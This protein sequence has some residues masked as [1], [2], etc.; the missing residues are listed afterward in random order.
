MS[1]PADLVYDIAFIGSG[2]ACT[3]TL[4]AIIEQLEKAEK[5]TAPLK[6][7]VIEKYPEWWKGI[8]Y[9]NRSSVNAL[10]ITTLHDFFTDIT[11]R[12]KFLNR[13]IPQKDKLIASYLKTGGTIAGTWLKSNKN[14][15]E[16]GDWNNV[17][18]PRS[19]I[20]QY[21]AKTFKAL[22]EQARSKN[23]IKIDTLTGEAVAVDS[24]ENYK[25]VIIAIEAHVAQIRARKIVLAI[26][27]APQRTLTT[28]F[29][30]QDEALY[31]NNIHGQDLEMTCEAIKKA[32]KKNLTAQRNIFIAGANASA[33][34]LL[35]L[36]ND[37]KEL[38]DLVNNIT[39][40]SYG[41]S[42]PKGITYT[43][44]A[45]RLTENLEK[46]GLKKTY[47][48]AELVE[49]AKKD[50]LKVIDGDVS[51]PDVD[52]IM[53]KTIALLTPLDI[54]S[55]KL[56]YAVH[57][58]QLARIFRRSGTDYKNAANNLVTKNKLT[59]LK[60][61][62][63]NIS[64]NSDGSTSIFYEVEDGVQCLT[65]HFAVVV[66]CTGADDLEKTTSKLIQN[67]INKNG[68]KI[69]QSRKAFEVDS[70][71]QAAEGIYVIGPLAGGNYNELLYFWHLE[72]AS[73]IIYLSKHLAKELVN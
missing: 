37:D 68:L 48:L 11:E 27:S 16:Q 46:L 39:M 28:A 47:S 67:L 14:A 41:G 33:I 59:V 45:H 35:Y 54:Q 3:A 5:K 51:V 22:K 71:L 12:D 40:L 23:L 38:S 43:T 58:V 52:Q 49:A 62:L 63:Q 10:T 26:G 19:I 42:L 70:H 21:L 4:T 55:K 32:L 69:N 65:D 64:Y 9:G 25:S 66:N 56:F 17:Y 50:I 24:Q 2:I 61:S 34:E 57:G 60:G 72:N 73:R 7:I 6:V 13:F 30:Q 8:P 31:L 36:L 44:H 18:F 29:K 1:Q 53:A 20:G 15:I